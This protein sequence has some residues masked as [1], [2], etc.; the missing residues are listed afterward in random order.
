MKAVILAA[1][2][3][4]RLRPI[5]NEKPKCLTLIYGE[6]LLERQLSQ[7]ERNGIT[8]A[9][10]VIGYRS[11]EILSLKLKSK[12]KKMKVIFIENEDFESTNNMYSLYLTK[13]YINGSPFLLSNGDVIFE[14]GIIQRVV[15]H[16]K[17]D[18][19]AVDTGV[20]MEESMKVTTDTAGFIRDISKQIKQ[21]DFFACSIDL[22]KFSE[23][24]SLILFNELTEIIENK[25]NLKEWTEVAIQSLLL[26]NQLMMNPCD[27]KGLKWVEIDDNQ[28]L[29]KADLY[30]SRINQSLGHVIETK[31]Q[32]FIDLD[33]TLF[34]GNNLIPH[35]DKFI[36]TL[37]EQKVPFYLLSN[38]SSYSKNKLVNKLKLMGIDVTESDILLS[39]D[40]VINY[41][42][43]ELIKKTFV[44]GTKD[45]KDMLFNEGIEVESGD[46]ELVVIG[47]D[48]ELTYSN[49][50]KVCSFINKGIPY[51]A[52]HCDL[53]CPTPDGPIPDIGSITLIIE[54]V[55]GQKP[56]KVFGKPNAEMVK[57]IIKNNESVYVIGDRLYTDMKLAL[58]ISANFICVLSGET[59]RSAIEKTSVFPDLII[60]RVSELIPY[61]ILEE[62]NGFD[63]NNHS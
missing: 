14:D 46:P 31:S 16:N 44:L 28:D 57:H 51:I 59:S 63:S 2:I 60:N 40:G 45:M 23:E 15:K 62:S 9:Y 56:N 37:K 11:E 4:S 7:Y 20:Y 33:G 10:V 8:E 25:N 34:V 35:S 50:A 24:S 47:Y 12:Y 48:T 54:Q 3:G 49:L 21:D 53:T 39:T 22:Y 36:K 17:T 58:N 19:I 43:E 13:R 18:L 5:T 26:N 29:A 1:G 55:T 27:I 6:S 38:N 61:L 30:F 32:F 42:K 52:S 41:L